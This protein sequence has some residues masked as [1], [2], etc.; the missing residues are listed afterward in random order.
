[1]PESCHNSGAAVPAH[2]RLIRGVF[3]SRGQPRCAQIGLRN[4]NNVQ[5]AILSNGCGL[6]VAIVC[7]IFRPWFCKGRLV[8]TDL[9]TEILRSV[10]LTAATF[11]CGERV[12]K[13]TKG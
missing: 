5:T 8:G 1:M 10:G 6:F 11:L 9:S 7:A 13:T 3:A 4:T 2:S 12:I